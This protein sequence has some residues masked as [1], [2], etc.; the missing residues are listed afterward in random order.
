LAREVTLYVNKKSGI[1][2]RSMD[3]DRLAGVPDGAIRLEH[4]QSSAL[5]VLRYC[6]RC[7]PPFIP[8]DELELREIPLWERRLRVLH[9]ESLGV[10][11]RLVDA[12]ARK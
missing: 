6:P 1:A 12:P 10:V 9:E 8:D 4:A 2:H 7:F 3:C 11:G 5:P